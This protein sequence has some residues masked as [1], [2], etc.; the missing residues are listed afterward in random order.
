MK[1][2]P[3]YDVWDEESK[4]YETEYGEEYTYKGD[5]DFLY[6]TLADDK[7]YYA[8]VVED[9]TR[10]KLYSKGQKFSIVNGE[11]AYAVTE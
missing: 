11:I 9:I 4:T 5:N 7:Y 1:F 3:I 2:T 10:E 6:T 8:V